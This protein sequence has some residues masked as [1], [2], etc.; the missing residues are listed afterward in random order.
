MIGKT[1][2]LR[3]LSSHIIILFKKELLIFYIPT[4]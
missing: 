4:D 1:F 3:I 2:I